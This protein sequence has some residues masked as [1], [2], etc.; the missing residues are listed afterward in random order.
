MG[1]HGDWARIWKAEGTAYVQ[2]ELHAGVA[3]VFVD[4]QIL[5]MKSTI[6]EGGA[7]WPEYVERNFT[8]RLL[9]LHRRY[10]TVILAFDNYEEVPVY[11]SIEQ[12]RRVAPS[13]G[14]AVFAFKAGDQIPAR[15]PR[16]DV[17]AAAML[18]RTFKTNVISMITTLLART[19]DPLMQRKTLVLDFVNVVRID[20][21][22]YERTQALMPE[23]LAM[24]ESDVK[25]M[26]YADLFG[27]IVVES[28]DSDVVLIAMLYLQRTEFKSRVFVKRIKSNP[29][30][31]DAT[32]KRKRTDAKGAG[33][34]R[35]LEY[36]V[37]CVGTLLRMLHA[38]C[39]QAVGPELVMAEE[40]LTHILVCVMLLCGSDYSRGI[41]RV[42]A[43]VLWE[44]LDIVVPAFVAASH[45]SHNA[46]VVDADYCTDVV[47]GEIYRAKFG[48]H[49][50]AEEASF[51]AVR[52]DLMGSK[53]SYAVKDS[54]PT[55]GHVACTLKNLAWVM[56]YWALDNGPPPVCA[57]GS[58][59][60]LV[61]DGKVRFA[62]AGPL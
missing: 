48:K 3:T 36:E 5:L 21:S 26:R 32:A 27:D 9:E 34:A 38:A 7:S 55:P 17:W 40:H 16:Q 29:I 11:K 61:A 42:G 51:A 41:P 47:F 56:H 25:F 8:R 14:K 60:F 49:V 22:P 6:P 19:Y 4:G 44:M 43:K 23:M 50:R 33:R 18:N 52:A 35:G 53:L 45:M 31:E 57:E 13:K 30:D 12:E 2:K 24:G 28:V 39:V 20:F 10:Q 46:I 37:V 1:I 59:G 58:H 62:D 54:I 15:P